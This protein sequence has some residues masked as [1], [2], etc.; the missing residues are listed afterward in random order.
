MKKLSRLT[1]DQRNNLVAYLDGELE[2]KEAN[3]IEQVLATSP[4]A[5]SEVETLSRT[6]KLL[7]HLPEAK[8]SENFTNR[9]VSQAKLETATA[10]PMSEQPWFD[11][12]RRGLIVVGWVTGLVVLTALG[13][14]ITSRMIPEQNAGLVKE[15]PVVNNI[16]KYQ[17]IGS[18]EFLEQLKKSGLFDEST[19]QNK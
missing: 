10:P 19:S 14:A 8:A 18:I 9:T 15:L 2:E 5:R 6:W 7:D 13:F 1:S 11:K 12:T 16:E 4:I 17:E 3:E